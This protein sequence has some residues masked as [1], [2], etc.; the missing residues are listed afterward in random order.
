MAEHQYDQTEQSNQ[1][2]FLL[3]QLAETTGTGGTNDATNQSEPQALQYSHETPVSTPVQ[4]SLKEEKKHIP[5]SRFL[6]ETHIDPHSIT[7]YSASLRY[8]VEVLAREPMFKDN[9][10]L[11]IE[12]QEHQ[13]K[14]WYSERQDI[15]RRQSIRDSGRE[16][17]ASMLKMVGGTTPTSTSEAEKEEANQKELAA[18]D[19]RV[20]RMLKHLARDTTQRLAEL[21][22]PLFCIRP[23]LISN[24][25]L[26]D[27]KKLLEF[28]QD[29]CE[30]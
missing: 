23:E 25:V 8:V 22:V 14:R 6:Q 13:E 4:P 17:L 7:T 3:R 9:V 18:F 21:R 2:A 19:N 15:V 12:D 10:R 26:Q 1:L 5:E 20:Y 28:L 29:F 16:K 30:D 24:Q 27:R 11:L